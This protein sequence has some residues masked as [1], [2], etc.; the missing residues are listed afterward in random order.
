M[1]PTVTATKKKRPGIEWVGGIISV[2]AYVT[3]EGEPYRP[4]TLVWMSAA[5]AVVGSAVSKPEEILGMASASLREAIERPMWGPPH[6][7][8]RV[9]V[10]SPELAA[11][12]REGHPG[13]DVVCAPTPEIDRVLAVMRDKMA[14]DS[15]IQPSYLAPDIGPDAVAAFFRAAAGLFRARPWK[16]VPS[17][18]SLFSM[19]IEEL[20][21][22][23]IA[24]SIIGHL[25]QSRGFILFSDIENFEAF[26]DAAEAM[27]QGDEP[28]LPPHFAL[29]F[30]RGAELAPALRKEIAAHRWEVAGPEA[31]PWLAA[32]DEDLVARP[33]TAGEVTM[34][35]A[36]ALAL[37]RVLS[38]KKAL[39]AA[40]KGGPVF[41]RRVLVTTHAGPLEVVLR[42]PFEEATT[43]PP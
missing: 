29:S 13:L 23:D 33:P 7:P 5:G 26:L 12:L 10:A 35:E 39:L 9:R 18:R 27:E 40:W 37:V 14:E 43:P 20:G 4:A 36:V 34:A 28:V 32:M 31:H 1:V 42:A 16:T 19:T 17:D 6:A 3:G 21:L 22:R 24:M 8:D 15:E 25:G 41:E 11:A 30:E 2:P 38:E